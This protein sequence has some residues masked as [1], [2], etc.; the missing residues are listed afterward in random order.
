MKRIPIKAA[1]EIAEKFGYDQIVII[2]RAVGKGEHVTTYGKDKSNCVVAKTIGEFLKFKVMGWEEEPQKLEQNL[3][4]LKLSL[5]KITLREDDSV[6]KTCKYVERSREEQE[7]YVKNSY[8]DPLQQKYFD[9]INHCSPD[10]HCSICEA[11]ERA[12]RNE[13]IASYKNLK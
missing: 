13:F 6:A 12:R 10:V 8:R 5:P 4:M 7:S 3:N 1:K 11:D 2:A 9:E